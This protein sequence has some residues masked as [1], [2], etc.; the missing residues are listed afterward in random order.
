MISM[1]VMCQI[2]LIWKALSH[3]NVQPLLGI[4]DAMASGRGRW[5]YFVIPY[6]EH[7]TLRRWRNK[8]NPSGAEIRDRVSQISRLHKKTLAYFSQMLEVARAIQYIHSL[9][10][11]LCWLC[12]ASRVCVCVVGGRP[13]Y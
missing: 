8:V 3:E 6:V 11:V 10:L 2:A 4:Y 12:G 9:G 7:G 5:L 13:D 1:K